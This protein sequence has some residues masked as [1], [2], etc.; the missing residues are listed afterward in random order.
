MTEEF[1]NSNP[2]EIGNDA[3]IIGMFCHLSVF[4][5]GIIIPLIFWITNKDKS[6]FITFH[7]LQTLW[8]HIVYIG[9]VIILALFIAFGAIGI[10]IFSSGSKTEFSAFFI[11][12]MVF[13]Y[14]S[15]FLV[16]FGVIAYSIYMAIK[17]YQGEKVKYILVG[18]I[19]YKKVYGVD[20]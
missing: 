1:G 12:L 8:F 2:N 18:N 15:I 17:T 20:E 5:G 16:V 14:G 7:S 13:L 6:K 19:I 3:R 4:F 10:G 11:I 9:I